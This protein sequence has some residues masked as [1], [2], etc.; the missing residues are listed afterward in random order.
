MFANINRKRFW[1]MSF[2]LVSQ[3]ISVLLFLDHQKLGVFDDIESWDSAKDS[4]KDRFKNILPVALTL[5]EPFH[6]FPCFFFNFYY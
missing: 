1:T 6:P 5:A 4:Q 2:D 3:Q